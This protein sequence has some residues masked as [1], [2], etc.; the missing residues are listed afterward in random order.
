LANPFTPHL[1]ILQLSEQGTDPGAPGLEPGVDLSDLLG[2]QGIRYQLGRFEQLPRRESFAAEPTEVLYA[3]LKV[4]V[5]II[6]IHI[7]ALCAD[8][9]EVFPKCTQGLVIMAPTGVYSAQRQEG[10]SP[11]AGVAGQGTLGGNGVAEQVLSSSQIAACLRNL[12]PE[13]VDLSTA[14][15]MSGEAHLSRQTATRSATAAVNRVSGP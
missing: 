11:G 10:H 14:S 9:L 5:H 1:L 2:H 15:V 7:A 12:G 13:Y 4:W 6:H 8:N 3:D